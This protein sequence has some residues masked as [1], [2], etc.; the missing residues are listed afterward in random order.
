MPR[1]YLLL[2]KCELL[3]ITLEESHLLLLSLAI[4][5]ANDVV[6]LLFDLIELDLEFNNLR[7]ERNECLTC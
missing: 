3:K 1:P 4:A 2:N 7:H 6:V 5:I